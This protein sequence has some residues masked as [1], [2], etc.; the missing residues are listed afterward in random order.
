MSPIIQSLLDTDLY[1]FTMQQ[2]VYHRFPIA[3]A[4][5]TFKCR[6][7]GIDLRPY[8]EEIEEEIAHFCSLRL[9]D[10]EIDYLATLPYLKSSYL[11]ALRELRLDPSVV[12]IR[13]DDEFHLHIRGNWYRTILFEVPVLA[14]VNEVYFRNTHPASAEILTEGRRRLEE[15]CRLARE[16]G[17]QNLRII[18]FGTRRRYSREWQDEVVAGLKAYLP[19][20]FLGTSNVALAWKHGLK[21]YGTMAHEFLQACQAFVALPD[22]QVYALETWMQEYRGQLGIALSDVVG[23]DAF[24]RDFD[25]LFSQAYD[26]ARHDSGDA[27]TWGERL[28]AHYESLGLDP[29]AKQAVFTDSLDIAR[30]IELATHFWGRIGTQFGIGTNL[31]NDLGFPALNIVIKMTRC[32]GRPVAKLSDAPGK[33]MCEDAAYMAYL[34][35]VFPPGG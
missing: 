15:K 26:G 24:F 10:V 5:F 14:I 7:A 17:L 11:S 34:R 23:M 8:R 21:R 20:T 2:V 35:T 32:N 3:E 25:R 31:T 9:T 28:V 1:K 18:E 33:T 6:N 12:E 27:I 4:E 16:S 22:S 29:R 19:E 13:C 30:A